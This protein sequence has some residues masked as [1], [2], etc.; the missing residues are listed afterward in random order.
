LKW[1]FPCMERRE[2]CNENQDG[3][4]SFAG[5]EHLGGSRFGASLV[6]DV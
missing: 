3:D 6:R 2:S 5:I 1:I 4:W